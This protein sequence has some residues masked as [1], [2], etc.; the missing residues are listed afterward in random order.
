[1]SDNSSTEQEKISTD[2][3]SDT[4]NNSSSNQ[5]SDEQSNDDSVENILERNSS[6]EKTNTLDNDLTPTE[7]RTN[8][9]LELDN[10]EISKYGSEKIEEVAKSVEEKTDKVYAKALGHYRLRHK[11]TS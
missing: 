7:E 11:V 9:E 10:K 4:D 5:A 1:M 2:R 3:K 6:E 8:Q